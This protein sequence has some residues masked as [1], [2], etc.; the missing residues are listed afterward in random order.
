MTDVQNQASAADAGNAAA[1]AAASAA[2]GDQ[3]N[4]GA[5]Q[6]GG[7]QNGAA[8]GAQG[9]N[10]AAG[11]QSIAAG[12]EGQQQQ[13]QPYWPEDWR[14]KLAEHAS[15]GDKKLYDKELKRLEAMADPT[16]VYGSYRAIEN[17]WASRKFIKLPGDGSKPEEIAEFHKAL[18]VPEKP[19]DY[20]K[21]VKLENGAVIG[22]ADKPIVD[23]FAQAVH[24]AGAPPQVVN[25][26]LNWYFKQQEDQAAALDEADDA[27]K[28]ESTTTLK[29]M[30][31][32]A[33]KRKVNATAALFNATSGGPDAK[34]EKSFYARLLGGRTADG[35]VIGDDPEFNNWLIGLAQE[36]NP[37][38]TVVEDG[39]QSG[40]SIDTEIRDIE[41]IMRTD[42]RRYNKEFA[43][44]YAELLAARGKIQARRA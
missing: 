40:K 24:K 33:F 13:A 41:Q 16:Q 25:A 34:N 39:D 10:G 19:E 4:G 20:F 31:G 28:R 7:A 17:T 6:N 44:R 43:G 11:N 36:I 9:A 14:V 18:G 27:F 26:A 12:G 38:M 2:A 23:A 8:N 42:R 30:H 5:Q 29:E 35:R 3:N 32:A 37:A 22:E 15:A 1:A 21:D